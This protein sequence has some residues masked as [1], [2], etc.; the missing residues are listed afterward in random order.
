MIEFSADTLKF[1]Y[2]GGS[3][4]V[5]G[6]LTWNGWRKGVARQGMTLLAIASAYA[7]GFFGRK[8]AAPLFSFLGYP[9]FV[10]EIIGA[11]AAGMLTYIAVNAVSRILFRKDKSTPEPKQSVRF[12]VMGALLGFVFAMFLF[13]VSYYAVRMMGTIAASKVQSVNAELEASKHQPKTANPHVLQEEPPA[14]IKGLAKLN[15]ALN[16]GQ[17][18]EFFHKVDRVPPNVYA[19]LFK[20]GIMVSSEESLD[21][22]LGYPG[23]AALARHP[24]LA[25]LKSDA[26]VSEL[27]ASKSYLKLLRN[28]KIVALANDQE[29]AQ[30]IKAMDFE[31]ALDHA[32]KG[33]AVAP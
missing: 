9:A 24:K 30:E 19:M 1:A 2:L 4:I 13:V 7:A 21:R 16:E 32:I 8:T 5:A 6:F 33:G 11:V 18:G 29:F 26:T 20:L 17:T 22:F 31:K 28:E 3:G 23:V 10:T 14:F 15:S 25:V 12:G 27:L